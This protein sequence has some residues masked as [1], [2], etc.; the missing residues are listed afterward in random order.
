MEGNPWSC[1]RSRNAQ[2]CKLQP[3]VQGSY[4]PRVL[5]RPTRFML[6]VIENL[7]VESRS[8]GP[9]YSTVREHF[10]RLEL[11]LGYGALIS[12]WKIDVLVKCAP[13]P[14]YI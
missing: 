6:G 2:R 4:S 12:Q 14:T 3:S 5:Y 10:G 11:L 7:R 1:K 9:K 13:N 8:F